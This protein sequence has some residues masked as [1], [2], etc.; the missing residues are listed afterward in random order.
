M[1]NSRPINFVDYSCGHS[2]PVRGAGG[3]PARM[4]PDCERTGKRN[5]DR[6]LGMFTLERILGKAP[7]VVLPEAS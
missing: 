6:G 3:Q 2:A 1:T 5:L 4:C 7:S